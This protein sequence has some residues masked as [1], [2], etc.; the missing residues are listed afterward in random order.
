MA[1]VL[2]T[3]KLHIPQL[4]KIWVHRP[5][6]V[7]RLQSSLDKKLILISTPAGYGKTTLVLDWLSTSKNQAAWFSLD[8]GDNDP[9]RFWS[10]IHYTLMSAFPL[11]EDLSISRISPLEINLIEY[12][13]A[14]ERYQS[15]V[16]LVIDDYHNIHS[17]LIHD[18]ISFLINHAPDNFHLIILTR[19]DPPLP[20]ARLRSRLQMVEF[21]MAE[22]CFSKKEINEFMHNV[23]HLSL[24]ESD[25]LL[26]EEST[27]GWIAGLQM[28]GLSLQ[29]RQNYSDYI[30]SISGEDRY[31]MDFL[32]EEVFSSQP[33]EIQ[34]F[35]LQTAPISLAMPLDR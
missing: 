33:E 30:R 13:N 21:R 32:F 35:L 15:S 25:L 10:Y 4:R 23:M 1:E 14:I 19:A 22:L 5:H 24:S 6:L 34:I 3:T 20:L 17:Q 18:G 12:L 29:G 7:A 2:L 9:E 26:L 28:I 31:I 8:D 16:I 11:I 27:E